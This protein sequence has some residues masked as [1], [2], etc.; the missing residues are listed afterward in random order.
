M[1]VLRRATVMLIMFHLFSEI[2]FES[3]NIPGLYIAV[4]VRF[5]ILFCSKLV[6]IPILQS[7]V[8]SM[9]KLITIMM[10]MIL[11]LLLLLYFFYFRGWKTF[12]IN[13]RK[14]GSWGLKCHIAINISYKSLYFVT[15]KLLP[16]KSCYFW[17]CTLFR[18][19]RPFVHTKRVNPLTETTLI[20]NR[21]REQF[22]ALFIILGVKNMQIQRCR[23]SFGYSPSLMLASLSKEMR[24]RSINKKF[25][26]FF[27]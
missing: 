7:F 26:F 1:S 20:W 5:I 13:C 12:P 6:L 25:P 22:K 9:E 18:T 3:F 14:K 8:F 16:H 10:M 27:L 2:M 4:Q 19:N 24:E 11:L 17:N 21:S 23:D 15:L